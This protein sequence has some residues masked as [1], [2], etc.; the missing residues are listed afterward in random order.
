MERGEGLMRAKWEWIL[1]RD[2]AVALDGLTV[3]EV[4][5]SSD[6]ELENRGLTEREVQAVRQTFRIAYEW[7]TQ[8]GPN[9]GEPVNDAHVAFDLFRPLFVGLEVEHFYLATLTNKN[10]VIRTVLISKGS[11]TGATV[12][13]REVFNEAIRDRA[14]RIIVAHNH[15]SG[16]VTPS[17]G[18]VEITERIK[19][20][21]EVLGIECL[22]HIILGFGDDFSSF[23]SEGLL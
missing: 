21:G 14:A 11:L 13:P 5:H 8:R 22:A 18:D 15:P 12:H 17:R 16:D 6:R 3:T 7:Y 20:V 2:A 4:S 19:Q 1:G 23:K 9:Q 10:H